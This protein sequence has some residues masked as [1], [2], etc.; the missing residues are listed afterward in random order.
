MLKND[1][2]GALRVFS[3][4]YINF[5]VRNGPLHI[6]KAGD[7]QRVK[8]PSSQPVRESIRTLKKQV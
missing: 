2:F 7:Q 4:Y 1:K 5:N 6:G 3:W 8:F